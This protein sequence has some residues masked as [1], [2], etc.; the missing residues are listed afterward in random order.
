MWWNRNKNKTRLIKSEMDFHKN[1]EMNIINENNIPFENEIKDDV[2]DLNR[3]IPHKPNDSEIRNLVQQDPSQLI[4]RDQSL[5]NDQIKNDL[6]NYYTQIIKNLLDRGIIKLTS[7]FIWSFNY[8]QCCG[9]GKNKTSKHYKVN[10]L[11]EKLKNK[12]DDYFDYLNVIKC[13]DEFELVKNLVFD[14]HELPLISLMSIPTIDLGENFDLNKID[15]KITNEEEK[16]NNDYDTHEG[17]EKLIEC[18]K[19]EISQK[20]LSCLRKLGENN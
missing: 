3:K 17:V 18:G 2:V 20:I 11:L 6:K 4:R 12:I 15:F 16:E 5:K 14:N 13:I 10:F 1:F 9:Y 7:E 8:K 19:R